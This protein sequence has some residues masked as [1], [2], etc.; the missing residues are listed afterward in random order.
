MNYQ[1]TLSKMLTAAAQAAGAHWK[2]FQTFA[3]QEIQRLAQDGAW[4][5]SD[6]LADL[7]AAQKQDDA[8]RRAD[9]EAKAKRRA[10]LAYQG[11]ELASEGLVITT[12]A[13]AKIAAQD[14]INA[15]LDI[16]RTAINQS[17]GLA[18]L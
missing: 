12:K 17:V 7:A 5:E 18:L 1:E 3:S 2:G 4:I 11:L 14:A 6:F 15:A 10:S 9:L 8:T 13:A 16:L